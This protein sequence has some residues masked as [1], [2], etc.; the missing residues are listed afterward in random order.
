MVDRDPLPL[1]MDLPVCG[2]PP[3]LHPDSPSEGVQPKDQVGDDENR[4]PLG[5]FSPECGAKWDQVPA[6]PPEEVE[7]KSPRHRASG[8]HEPAPGFRQ[9][10]GISGGTAATLLGLTLAGLLL[11]LCGQVV[12]LLAASWMLPVPWCYFSF[13]A[14]VLLLGLV[15]FYGI[16]LAWLFRKFRHSPQVSVAGLSLGNRARQSP[17]VQRE[18]L[19]KYL[20]AVQKN[21]EPWRKVLQQAGLNQD[22]TNLIK[23]RL[24]KLLDPT[25]GM[26]DR[27]WILKCERDVILL[28]DRA[29]NETIKNQSFS[30]GIK[31]A[32]CPNP[33]ID[34]V[35]VA[36]CSLRL[37][38]DL[39]RIYGL[40]PTGL[41]VLYLL[42]RAFGQAYLAGRL[43]DATEAAAEAALGEGPG[44]VA[45]IFG[46][47]APKVA[48]G[49]ANALL[50]Y[51]LGRSAKQLVRPVRA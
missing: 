12:Q 16:R 1:G 38:G 29:A 4:L 50:L 14:I 43:E 37:I 23:S 51:R 22:E 28:L 31:T 36:A 44:I 34:T 10:W 35:I 41:R 5:M 39:C 20:Q 3:G 13:G 48:Q 32:A 40:R 47:V 24:E 6:S 2:P 18:Q 9:W 26:D 45:N 8:D 19:K 11:L 46:R 21:I 15:C 33:I 42:C 30:L 49:A 7:P 27:D 25:L 17:K